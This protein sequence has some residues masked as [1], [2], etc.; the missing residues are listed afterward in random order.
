MF[1]IDGGHTRDTAM[2]DL[3]LI[4]KHVADGGIVALDDFL[5]K[6]WWGVSEAALEYARV[7][8]RLVPLVFIAN[9]LFYTTPSHY[10]YYRSGLSADP[11][12]SRMLWT[13]PKRNV[14]LNHDYQAGVLLSRV[15]GE[16][17]W[18]Q[19][20]VSSSELVEAAKALLQYFN[21]TS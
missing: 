19:D 3:L 12:L 13:Q 18:Y 11:V 20:E 1:S 8:T 2:S 4:E 9:K 10:K 7:G 15:F 5:R 16:M 6:D 21:F 14:D 17:S